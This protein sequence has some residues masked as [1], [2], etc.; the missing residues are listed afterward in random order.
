M[1]TLIIDNNSYDGSFSWVNSTEV[2]LRVYISQHEEKL[3]ERHGCSA[4][5]PI[6]YTKAQNFNKQL[7]LKNIVMHFKINW[8]L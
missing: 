4:T 8:D 2:Y 7:I 5:D 1:K 3:H 6:D